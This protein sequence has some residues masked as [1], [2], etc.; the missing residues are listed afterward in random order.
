MTTWYPLIVN[1]GST[2]IQ[3]LPSGQDLNLTGSN[4]SN[5]ASITI[6]SS[7][8]AL[9]NG[10][11]NTVGNI[12]SSTGYF[13][14]LFATASKALY[15]DIAEN[16][17]AD[18]ADYIPG[19]V[20]CFD[21]NAEVTQ[22]NTDSC[23]TVAGV[24]SSA[25]AYLMNSGLSGEHI[26]PVALLGRVPCRVQGTVKKGSMMVSAGN[27]CARAESSPT[28]GTVIGKAVESFDGNVGTIEIVVGR[29]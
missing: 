25:P 7:S 22:C 10:S 18:S 16:Y 12:G 29:L 21:G 17:L 24:V 3:E 11:G 28:I 2:Q 5:V 9:I 19:T 15:A 8:T 27:G 20:L 1:P 13:N 14:T 4:I 26:V 23:A 6:T